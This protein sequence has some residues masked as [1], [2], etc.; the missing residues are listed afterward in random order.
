M[1]YEINV[2]RVVGEHRDGA[3]RYAHFFATASRS[4][5]FQREAWEAFEIFQAKFPFSEGY[6]ISMT[7]HPEVSTQLVSG[8][9]GHSPIP[10]LKAQA[11]IIQNML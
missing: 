3:P 10:R 8:K 1:Y 4:L 9:E 11:T 5:T 7:L 2:A 6:E